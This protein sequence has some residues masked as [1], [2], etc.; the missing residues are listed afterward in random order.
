MIDDS[1]YA[2]IIVDPQNDFCEGGSLAVPDADSIFDQINSLKREYGTVII[3]QDW[4][5]E[6]HMSF[7]DN[8]D[9]EPFSV[10]KMPIDTVGEV[11]QVMWP[12]HCVQ[13]T[14]GAQIHHLLEIKGDEQIVQKGMN[15]L[16]DSY[17]GFGDFTEDKRLEKTELDEILQSHN[18]EKIDVV[19]L[20]YNYCVAYTA[21][22]AKKLGYETTVICTSTRHIPDENYEKE[23]MEM[24]KLGINLIHV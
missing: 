6:D 10:K 7:A 3:T 8:N 2:L 4:H 11:D 9:A 18:I 13:G 14:V 21:K 24:L 23:T 1:T 19:G 20:A 5:P 12:R 15:P 16:V 22:D 17:S